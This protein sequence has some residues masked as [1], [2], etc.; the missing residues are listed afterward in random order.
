MLTGKLPCGVFCTDGEEDS[1]KCEGKL[2]CL[3][4]Q[5]DYGPGVRPVC[6]FLRDEV[7]KLSVYAVRDFSEPHSQGGLVPRMAISTL[8]NNPAP[9]GVDDRSVATSTCVQRIL[10][11]LLPLTRLKPTPNVIAFCAHREDFLKEWLDPVAKDLFRLSKLLEKE[12]WRDSAKVCEE[13]WQ[14]MCGGEWQYSANCRCGAYLEP[15]QNEMIYGNA[16]SFGKWQQQMLKFARQRH[17]LSEFEMR[18]LV[19]P[20][21]AGVIDLSKK[22]VQE[23]AAIAGILGEKAAEDKPKGQGAETERETSQYVFKQEG[24]TWRIIYEGHATTVNDS[25]GVKC[26]HYLMRNA[27]K[28]I[29]CL[30]L[31]NACSGKPDRDIRGI[32]KNEAKDKGIDGGSDNLPQFDKFEVKDLEKARDAARLKAEKTD[33]PQL[34]IRYAEEAQQL[35][36]HLK[37]RV[38]V[39]G[40]G[41]PTGELEQARSRVQKAINGAKRAIDNADHHIGTHFK[42][43]VKA[44]GTA[45]IYK[46][47]RELTW[48][49]E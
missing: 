24:A 43:A 42:G 16:I 33:D 35:D 21:P 20:Y 9:S 22:L 38:N 2:F 36:A 5:R 47:D 19:N 17:C 31:D 6:P 27:N 23:L 3:E 32:G 41:R 15:P 40:E 34:S 13:L 10:E 44:D 49:L 39:H 29:E 14:R 12:G 30:D 28:A 11:Y 4:S 25:K 45:Y 37:K 1:A 48:I 18:R 8:A 26:I 46:P 7:R